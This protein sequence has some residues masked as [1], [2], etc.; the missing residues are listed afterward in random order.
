MHVCH[1]CGKDIAII[2][3][4]SKNKKFCNSSCAAIYNNAR[5]D[6]P[7]EEHKKKV[8]E[9]LKKRYASD[10]PPKV[11][12][13][14]EQSILVGKSTKYKYK[15]LDIKSIAECSSRTVSK[16]LKRMNVGCS[17]CGWKEATCDIH[18][19][20][21][22]KVDDPHNHKN[23]IIL[24]PNCHRIVHNHKIDLSEYKTIYDLFGET[25]KDY[26]YG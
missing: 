4:Y 7:T 19:I 21:G 6:P 1:Q 3:K 16:I 17:R 18:H 2:N 11:K 26:Y 8:S 9:S 24:C 20:N 10:N 25:W 23:L 15:G 22:R 14:K 13:P 5:R 12:P